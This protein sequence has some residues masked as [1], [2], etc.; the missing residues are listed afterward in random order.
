MTIQKQDINY[1]II[2]LLTLVFSISIYSFSCSQIISR[3]NS[4]LFKVERRY[5]Y[6][7]VS[8]CCWIILTNRNIIL[9]QLV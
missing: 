3:D 9:M 5:N 1:A 4:T 2:F 6:L 7:C 8:S